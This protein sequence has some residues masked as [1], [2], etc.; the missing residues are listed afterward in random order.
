MLS[1][2]PYGR[3][4]VC[5]PSSRVSQAGISSA[6]LNDAATGSPD[7]PT[8]GRWLYL[9][10]AG[11]TSTLNLSGYDSSTGGP[12]YFR[13]TVPFGTIDPGVVAFSPEGNPQP[14]LMTTP[15]FAE[16]WKNSRLSLASGVNCVFTFQMNRAR[17]ELTGILKDVSYVHTAGTNDLVLQG[18][19]SLISRR[20]EQISLD[21]THYTNLENLQVYVG[22]GITPPSS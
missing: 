6:L 13:I 20:T 22:T 8:P 16:A 4:V 18:D 3:M 1:R 7:S 14:K 17:T 5:P 10:T 19:I 9:I 15:G 21:S 2:G 12:G 11:N